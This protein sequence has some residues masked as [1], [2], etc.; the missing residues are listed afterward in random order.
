[1]LL[2]VC[3][4]ANLHCSTYQLKL[5][6]QQAGTAV[7]AYDVPSWYCDALTWFGQYIVLALTILCHRKGNLLSNLFISSFSVMLA[8]FDVKMVQMHQKANN[9]L[10]QGF[11]LEKKFFPVENIFFSN[12]AL[13]PVQLGVFRL[14]CYRLLIFT[15]RI[16]K[17]YLP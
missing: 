11:Q 3:V 9:P 13:F 12:W 17:D 1:M 16:C 15:L 5:Q 4:P 6:Y 10:I 2:Q 8:Y 14:S 7:P